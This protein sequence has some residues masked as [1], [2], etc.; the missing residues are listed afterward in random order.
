VS[1]RYFNVFGPRQDP[2]GMYAAV[3]PRFAQLILA[4]ER[5]LIHGD[6]EQT[7]DFCHVDN[8]VQANLKACTA[9]AEALG[10]VFN[11]GA[12]GRISLNE[13]TAHIL[14]L[15]GSDLEPEH[16]PPRAG[17]VRDS[18]ADIEKARRLLGYEPEVDVLEG[19][20]RAIGWYRENLK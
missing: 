20:E 2:E 3:I 7:R 1:L 4:G 10:Q 5:P 11:C 17:D 9:P 16:G 8:V 15:L 19:L 6:G 14:R 13:L 12:A 18:Q